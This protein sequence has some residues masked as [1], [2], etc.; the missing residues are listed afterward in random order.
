VRSTPHRQQI[1]FSTNRLDNNIP[2]LVKLLPQVTDMNVERALK[3]IRLALIESRCERIARNDPA[4]GPREAFEYAELHG[5]EDYDFP[6]KTD[7]P[8]IGPQ[9]QT[10][11]RDQA[12]IRCFI[13]SG[14]PQYSAHTRQQLCRI[15]GLGEIIVST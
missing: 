15:E 13:P 7:F 9:F 5:S 10:A 2:A 14:S 6:A 1:A 3:R 12:V 8:G 4:R 11:A